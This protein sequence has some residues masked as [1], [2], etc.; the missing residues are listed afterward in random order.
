LISLG[1]GNATVS[2]CPLENV[3]DS[4]GAI[5]RHDVDSGDS[6]LHILRV[7]PDFVFL[8]IEFLCST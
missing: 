6:C 7:V 2:V 4:L 3:L 5:Q 1:G 8:L